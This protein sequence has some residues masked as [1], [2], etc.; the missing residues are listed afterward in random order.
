MVL[1]INS[2]SLYI[3]TESYM[4]TCVLDASFKGRDK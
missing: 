2:S 4:K 3:F 1:V